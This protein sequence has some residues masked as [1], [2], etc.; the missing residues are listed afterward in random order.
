MSGQQN[1]CRQALDDALEG[2]AD[3]ARRAF[4][5]DLAA[6]LDARPRR[7]SPKYFYD[8]AGS[9]LFDR[10]CALPEYYPTRTEL[11]I[12]RERAHEIAAHVGPGAEIVEFGAGS[13]VKVRLL[14]DALQAPRRY[15]P[16]DISG[17]HLE[18]AAQELRAERP[19]LEVQPVVADYTQPFTLPEVE[20]A[21]GDGR[22]R[23][24]G[25]FPG[26]TLGNFD[27]PEALAFLTRAARLLRGGGLLLG[28]DLVK[29]PATLHAA[30]NDSQGVT[31]AFNRNVLVRAN[32]ELAGLGCDFDVGAFA[33]AAFYNAPLARIE[34]HL[35]CRRAHTVHLGGRSWRLEE[36]D[37]LHTESSYKYTVDG[38][39]ALA[40]RAGFGIG[41][42][43]TD[44]ARLF[45]VHWLPA[46]Q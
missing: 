27:P 28:V 30:Y 9:R 46:A 20:G 36:G 26:S 38:L 15:V 14:L 34:M 43:W 40:V 25:F 44:A 1:T 12:L 23:R 42:V 22:G 39:R 21:E 32:V 5:R 3:E 17:D 7:I 2:A 13:L 31:A 18:A 35:Q 33:H 37:T 10:I 4:A 16:I 19:G 29:E 6:G 8:A 11:S 41:P 45:S 24:V